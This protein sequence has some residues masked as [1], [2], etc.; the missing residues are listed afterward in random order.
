MYNN[1]SDYESSSFENFEFNN[2]FEGE[3]NQEFEFQNELQGEIT[4]S[5]GTFSES[6]QMELASELLNVSNEAEMEQF[7]GDLFKKAVGSANKFLRSKT[8]RAIGGMLKGIAKKALPI[9]GRVGGAALAGFGVPPQ[10]GVMAGGALGDAAS[11]MFELEMEGLSQEDREFETA[12]AFVRLAGNA[13]RQGASTPS[14]ANPTQAARQVMINSSRRYAPGL[15]RR[16]K[17]NCSDR[18]LYM[19]SERIGRLEEMVKQLLPQNGGAA[20]MENNSGAATTE[21]EFF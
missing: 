1:R 9:A 12:K 20:P 19:L 3:Y 8:G 6:T 21:F 15:L 4:D 5:E 10:I 13:A 14:A 18:G 11:G 2:E 7:L 17:C 16:K